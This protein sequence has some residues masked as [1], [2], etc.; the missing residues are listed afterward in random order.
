MK[1]ILSFIINV[2]ICIGL[3]GCTNN[4]NATKDDSNKENSKEYS[5]DDETSDAT[6]DATTTKNS[7]KKST[8]SKKDNRQKRVEDDKTYYLDKDGYWRANDG[9]V[10]N[11]KHG[12]ELGKKP[13]NNNDENDDADYYVGNKKVSKDEYEKY[14]KEQSDKIDR[15]NN[16]DHS[17][18]ID[19]G[20]TSIIYK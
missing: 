18:D 15:W 2:V 1:K 3:S 12:D 20:E 11:K 8:T 5:K 9:S 16:G 14:E 10:L 13:W 19:D 6:S 4:D 7:T 17:V